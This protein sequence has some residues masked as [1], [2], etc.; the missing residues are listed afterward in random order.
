MFAI[1]G[2]KLPLDDD[3]YMT[4]CFVN[5]WYNLPHE[6]TEK[7]AIARFSDETKF[8]DIL[9]MSKENGSGGVEI[10][11]EELKKVWPWT[12]LWAKPQGYIF[13]E[14]NEE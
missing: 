13:S 6:D 2:L 12:K 3:G 10:K 11:I 9:A 14:P 8:K 4:E 5:R 7:H 1:S